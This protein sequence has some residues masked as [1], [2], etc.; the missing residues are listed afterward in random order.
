MSAP[1]VGDLIYLGICLLY[2]L[3][4]VLTD[5][6]KREKRQAVRVDP[7]EKYVSNTILREILRLSIVLS[8]VIVLALPLIRLLLF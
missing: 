7:L 8:L 6:P 1:P 5:K 2:A 4:V 3:V